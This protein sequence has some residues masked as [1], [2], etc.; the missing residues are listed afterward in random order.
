VRLSLDLGVQH[1]LEDELDTASRRYK[2]EGAAGIVLDIKSGEVVASASLPA[3]DPGRPSIQLDAAHQDRVAGGTYELGSVFKTITLAMA[4]DEGIADSNRV[5]D[6]RQPLQAGRYTISDFHP[7]DRPLSVAE[8]FTHSSNVGAG[9]LALE[10]G[11]ERV[12]GFMKRLGLLDPMITEAGAVAP[13]QLPSRWERAE[14]I[15]TSYGHGLAVAPLQFAAAVATILNGGERVTPTLIRNRA[16]AER[17]VKDVVTRETSREVARLF[18]LNVIDADGT[19]KRAD[20]PGYRVGGKTG[21]ADLASSG[22]YQSKAVI[23][24]FLA[25]F[26]MDDPQYLTFIMLFEPKASAETGG[27]RTASTNAAPVT[28]RLIGRIAANL[29]VG[30]L[31]TQ[32]TQ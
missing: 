31:Q 6:V 17:A 25:A 27:Q 2:T 11:P 13:P 9:M 29:G 23:S 21:T 16:T 3:I 18:R 1:A 4:L 12:Q 15:T 20:V 19:G 10:A 28:A 32:P 8:I 30:P 5:L 14:V 22:G 24:S 26:P 7:S